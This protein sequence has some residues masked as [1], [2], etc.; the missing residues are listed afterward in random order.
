MVVL[1]FLLRTCFRRVG[2]IEGQLLTR[3]C[4]LLGQMDIV[5]TSQQMWENKPGRKVHGPIYMIVLSDFTKN[6]DSKP[7]HVDLGLNNSGTFCH[8]F[9]FEHIKSLLERL[10]LEYA[11]NLS[12]LL[13]LLLCF[14]RLESPN[15]RVSKTSNS[16]TTSWTCL[17]YRFPR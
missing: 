9:S 2:L 3:F 10:A 8:G 17:C 7:L 6:M 14:H 15:H 4:I 11:V 16:V 13:S 5:S 12:C 1:T